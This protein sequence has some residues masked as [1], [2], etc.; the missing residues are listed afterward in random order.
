MLF[1]KRYLLPRHFKTLLRATPLPS[2]FRRTY[3]QGTSARS[4]FPKMAFFS[5]VVHFSPVGYTYYKN[6]QNAIMNFVDDTP[7]SNSDSIA[8]FDL[9]Q[10]ASLRTR[11]LG[12]TVYSYKQSFP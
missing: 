4:V 3:R 11:F 6:T 5:S 10:D 1:G 9:E 8:S 12:E 7:V 2:F